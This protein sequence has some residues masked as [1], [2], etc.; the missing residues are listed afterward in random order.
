MT[1]REFLKKRSGRF[2]NAYIATLLVVLMVGLF[3]PKSRTLGLLLIL[4]PFVITVAFGIAVWRI[5]CPRCSRSLGNAASAA[6]NPWSERAQHCRHCGIDV[7]ES[8]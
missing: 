7:D 6:N 3:A 5:P 1:I 4:T 8:M 2:G